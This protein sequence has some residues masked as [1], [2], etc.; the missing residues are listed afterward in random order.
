[1]DTFWKCAAGFSY[2]L[3][4]GPLFGYEQSLKVKNNN[5]P[6]ILLSTYQSLLNKEIWSFV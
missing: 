4:I 3:V 2:C 6:F 1:M 5:Q